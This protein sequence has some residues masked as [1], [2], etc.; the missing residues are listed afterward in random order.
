MSSG[1]A[2]K[3]IA[4][5]SSLGWVDGS[6]SIAKFSNLTS[7]AVS[8][9]GNIFVADSYNNNIRKISSNLVITF[10]GSKTKGTL[11]G[12]GS[13]ALLNFPRGIA[14]V[15]TGFI[16]VAEAGGN[17]VR[18]ILTTGTLGTV[19][20]LAG[21]GSVSYADGVGTSA[22]INSPFDIV[23]DA[24]GNLFIVTADHRVRKISSGGVVTTVAGSGN[25]GF[26]DG[27]GSAAS[28]NSS[29]GLGIDSSGNL[30]IADTQNNRIRKVTS[31][32]V[33][34]TLAGSGSAGYADGAGFAAAFNSP[35]SAKVDVYGNIYVGDMG[36]Y[37]VRQVTGAGQGQA[38]VN[39]IAG[40]GASGWVD[41]VGSMA[42]FGQ[43]YG[44]YVDSSLR[45]YISGLVNADIR[46]LYSGLVK[47][48][49]LCKLRASVTLL[50]I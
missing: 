37:R 25:A 30:Y 22:S 12:Y 17:R 10:A 36:N 11:D 32:G 9:S 46:E 28:F 39:T 23:V 19:T 48:P 34:T 35:T 38:V 29:Q 50:C 24:F 15:T 6:G 33:V 7:L 13:A 14:I 2:V 3:T 18:K 31:S 44:L 42:S 8:T 40:S 49:G 43:I 45:I 1:Y 26:V 20:T 16:Y 5:S 21:N 4:G 27:I 47:I 41:G